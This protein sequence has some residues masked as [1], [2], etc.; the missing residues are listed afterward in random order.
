MS[1][2]ERHKK[3]KDRAKKWLSINQDAYD[4]SMPQREGFTHQEKGQQKGQT[5]Y[6]DIAQDGVIK[7]SGRIQSFITPAGQQFAGLAT[8]P[9]IALVE[10][11]EDLEQLNR[12]LQDA[13]EAIFDFINQSNFQTQSNEVYQDLAVGTGV[14]TVDASD[15]PNMV[16][17]NAVPIHEV[18]L[19]EGPKGSIESV[20][21]DH[22]PPARN[23]LRMWPDATIPDELA[24]IIQ[25]EPDTEVEIKAMSIFEPLEGVYRQVVYYDK[26]KL[27][28]WAERTNP[29]IVPRWAVKSGE[30][31]GRGPVII[32]L[33][34]IRSVNLMRYHS[35]RAAAFAT[36]PAWTA[37]ND[38]VINPHTIKIEPN[39]VI[40]VGTNDN[41]NPSL[42]PLEIGGDFNQAAFEQDK[43]EQS[44]SDALF[45]EPLP[46]IDAG[47][48]TATENNLRFQ[49]MLRQSGANL[50]RL[51]T[52]FIEPMLRRVVDILQQAGKIPEFVIDGRQVIVKHT[53]PLAQAQAQEDLSNMD[54]MLLRAQNLE[55]VAPGTIGMTIKTNQLPAWWAK[56]LGV[57]LDLINTTKEMDKLVAATKQQVKDDLGEAVDT[58]EEITD[59]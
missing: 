50:G 39:T 20:F 31:Y 49:E 28:E 16:E 29:Y 32:K 45:A 1:D 11:P 4:L 40:P 34:D 27:T 23:V 7:F 56:K 53:S 59:V 43:L 33:N 55:Q 10:D 52:E 13:N 18:Y 12:D 25:D 48:R 17:F 41:R 30:V 42:R 58:A 54:E 47:V 36:S 24:K 5:L 46:P 37:S 21:R 15:G 35:L 44:I 26:D 6:N 8:G 3:A 57:D 22:K 14:M 51:Q 19:E 2:L 38:G 9:D